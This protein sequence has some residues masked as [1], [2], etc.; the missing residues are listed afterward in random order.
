MKRYTMTCS[1]LVLACLTARPESR[2]ITGARKIN[3]HAVEVSIDGE[4]PRV[5]A[6]LR[7]NIFRLSPG[8]TPPGKPD[9]APGKILVDLPGLPPAVEL[10]EDDDRVSISTTRA[11]VL[12]DK[13]SGLMKV[14]N[15]ATG[16]VALEE[17]EPLAAGENG[18]TLTL[19]EHPDEHF[20]GGGVQNGRFS[21]KGKSIAI[22]NQN[23]W[24]DGGVASPTPFYW[25]TN[26]YGILFHTFRMGK[27]DFG[28]REKG[29][30]KL[31]HAAPAGDLFVMIDDEPADLLR[32]FYLLTGNPVLLPK[33]SFYEGHLNAYNRD[34]WVE[35]EEGVPF[36]DGKRYKESQKDNG[37]T[38]ESLNGENDN[39]PFSAR[40]VI[41]RYRLHDMPLGWILPND[42][43][44]AGYGQTETLDGNI[45]NLKSLGDYARSL[46]VEIG[47]WT[48]SDLYPKDGVSALLQR[49]IVKEVGEAGV[50]VLKTDVA[51]VGAGYR[52][53]LNAITDVARV[54][55][56]HG[57]N[58]R[59]F[60]ITLD[61]WA[62]TQR[63]AGV[64][65]GDQTGGAWEY[66]RF[67]V[68]TYIGSGL[69][70][71]PNITSD[72]DGI[73][74]GKNPVVNTRDFQW[75]AFTPMQLNMDGWG[76]NEKYPHAL[77]EPAT[78]INRW[79]LKLKSTLLPYA[80]SIA[81]EAV[82]GLPVIR[83]TFLHYPSPY[84]M[85]TA[86]RYQ[87][88]YGPSLLVAPVYQATRPDDE[89]NDARDGIYL[90][91]GYWIDY[92]TGERY[93]GDR[94]INGFDA[95]L[96]KL[97][98]FVKEGA[99]IPVTAPHNNPSEILPG[100]R[101][102]DV[103]PG[104]SGSFLEYDD[105][106]VSEEYKEG[107]GTTTL[108]ET[109][110]DRGLLT[111]TVHPT[112]G[113]FNGFTREKSTEFRIYTPL[114]PARVTA[115]VG[116]RRVRLA[117]AASIDDYLAR[118]NVYFHETA[119]D[120]NRFA[121]PGSDFGKKTI[122]G[123]SRLLVKLSPADIT[124]SSVTLSVRGI[125]PPPDGERRVATG[126]LLSP[127]NARVPDDDREPRALRLAWERVGNADG[128]EI[129][130][131]DT[132]YT[133]R[134]TALRFDDLTPETTY[135]F[136]LRS[137]NRD[138]QSP[139]TI[140]EAT[141]RVNPLEFAVKGITGEC[142]A[143]G[144]PGSGI[145]KLFDLDEE[146]MWH[147]AWGET[148]VPFDIVI[149]LNAM[150]QLDKLQ[151]LP[152]VGG[153]NGT[154]LKGSIACSRDGE[155]WT[156][157][158]DFTWTRRDPFHEFVFTGHPL[159]RYLKISVT[160]AR[161]GFGSGRELYVF[162]VP[163][164]GSLL[165]GDINND[166]RVDENDL[167]SYRNY[168]GLRRGDADFEGYVS[169]G[170]INDNGVIDAF[171]ISFA[172]ARD[173]HD[174]E[175]GRVDGTI[176][177]STAKRTYRAGEIIE[178]RARGIGLRS[179]NAFSLALPYDPRD[180]E[181]VGVQPLAARS[182]EN[183]TNDRTHSD[184][185]RVVYPTFVNAGDKESLAGTLDLCILR[186][187]AARDVKFSPEATDGLLVDKHPRSRAFGKTRRVP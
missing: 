41:D 45:Q 181:F 119:P 184:G 111:V 66:I 185:S 77:G 51:W 62:G 94:V 166:G 179:V 50:R 116:N 177:L 71:Q 147:T 168:T 23:S 46:G 26:G 76:T 9:D 134:D 140:V 16:A 162:R 30:V 91:P 73:F 88:L 104:A 124:A 141:T 22:E 112:A 136:Q 82:D 183:F 85:G 28:A 139:W 33:F 174:R 70:G 27:Y 187:K 24:T 102:Y 8:E 163:G 161:R 96:W 131:N 64:W 38:R 79:Y 44:G 67:H 127:A 65:T 173:V 92:F 14:I 186:F 158:G 52:F 165:P 125:V 72:M 31:S 54:M 7:E 36:E 132:R 63:Y 150:N 133:L 176:T 57:N 146:S 21:H 78:S 156:E 169:N 55:T 95:P 152:R 89:G 56:T 138:G 69:S 15:L 118:E 35:D 129:L 149:D 83:A 160:E 144:Q 53:G 19:R 18:I 123:A 120:L 99:I 58:C 39:Y 13:R 11:R 42:G 1:L 68:P 122:T 155:Q 84:T 3:A 20:Y 90:P 17:V 172:A 180:V 101:A 29:I 148:A 113:D 103:Y 48:Q 154:I 6:F 37:G 153:G 59:P 109:S 137:V 151:Y 93:E 182:M 81:R 61:G 108:V 86:T 170:D 115:R 5:I 97:P 74:G 49:D 175:T 130:F 98:V 171:D 142:S 32:D 178:V 121:T 40:A 143:A 114:P 105:D 10:D 25:S 4:Q 43:Y 164:T 75:K 126:L 12:L 100:A 107:K 34:Y 117:R 87:F 106:G 110:T 145:E 47:L 159:A 135:T 157:T 128:Y 60:I 2:A 167:T 80:Y